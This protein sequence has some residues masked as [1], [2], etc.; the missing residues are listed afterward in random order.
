MR[1]FEK[2]KKH[3]VKRSL[4]EQHGSASD[5]ATKQAISQHWKAL[6]PAARDTWNAP[7]MV[8]DFIQTQVA[9]HE[10]DCLMCGK[11]GEKTKYRV[12][13]IEDFREAV[14][15]AR[16]ENAAESEKKLEDMK[17]N[18]GKLESSF[19]IYKGEQNQ[20]FES[21]ASRMDRY[22]QQHIA[23]AP[24]EPLVRQGC[25]EQRER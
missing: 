21:L 4:R 15:N 7:A 19:Q 14:K 20:K 1:L 10:A 8:E 2:S 22:E 16:S 23:D 17:V 24:R 13:L 25:T 3:E 9:R 6:E 12:R 5:E 18:Y 11:K